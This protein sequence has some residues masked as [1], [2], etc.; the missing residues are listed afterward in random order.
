VRDLTVRTQVSVKTRETVD[1]NRLIDIESKLAHQE[2]MLG[3][4]NTALANQQKQLTLLEDL[5]E[6]LVSR[7]R[8]LSD[9]GPAGDP[10]DERPPHY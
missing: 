6:T 1:E 7:V 9:G 5:C 4:L 10:A 3:E 8:S 2:D